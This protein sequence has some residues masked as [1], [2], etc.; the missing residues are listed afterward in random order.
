MKLAERKEQR[1]KDT[2][3][4]AKSP[5][6]KFLF[7]KEPARERSE[8]EL[9]ERSSVTQAAWRMPSKPWHWTGCSL[10]ICLQTGHKYAKTSLT[11]PPC[12]LMHEILSWNSRWVSGR[13]RWGYILLWRENFAKFF[14]SCS[15]NSWI[16]HWAQYVC[17]Q[18]LS[19]KRWSVRLLSTRNNSQRTSLVASWSKD[20][21]CTGLLEI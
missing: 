15:R 2:S 21:Y 18:V 9:T 5:A 10:V 6:N 19:L 3:Y 4:L 8:T 1:H 12:P 20:K 13:V 11:I 14:I 17:P 16:M 7:L